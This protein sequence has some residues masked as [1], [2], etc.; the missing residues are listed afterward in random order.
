MSRG[1]R[2]WAGLSESERAD[3]ALET[4]HLPR[5]F[6]L[7]QALDQDIAVCAAVN[8]ITRSVCDLAPHPAG[9]GHE[10]PDPLNGRCAW[11][12][13]SEVKSDTAP[14]SGGVS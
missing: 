9:T 8:P 14:N 12:I 2:V 7:L 3:I 11:R 10:G 5:A 1:A 13:P 4:A 6:K